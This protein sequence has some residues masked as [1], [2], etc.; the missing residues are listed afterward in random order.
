MKRVIETNEAPALGKLIRRSDD[1]RV[2]EITSE[3]KDYFE[4][5][6]KYFCGLDPASN[7]GTFQVYRSEFN[8]QHN[9]IVHYNVVKIIETDEPISI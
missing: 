5:R 6:P 7:T 2:H 9:P 8:K 1:W 4:C 3:T